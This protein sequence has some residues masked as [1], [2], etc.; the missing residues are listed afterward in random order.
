MQSRKPPVG[1]RKDVF[2]RH[3]KINDRLIC[4]TVSNYF[5]GKRM[6]RTAARIAILVLAGVLTLSGSTLAQ[7]RRQALAP[8]SKA[9]QTP[10]P[11]AFDLAK[12]DGEALVWLEGLI[13]IN[14][15]NPP[16]NEIVA[17]K[18]VADILKQEGINSEIIETTPGRGFLVARLSATAVPDPSRALLLMGHLDVV[19]VDKTKWTV[20]P[21]GAVVK[22]GYLYGRGAIDDKAMAVANLAVF[23]ALKRSSAHLNR[24]VIYLAEGDE[25]AGGTNGMKVAVEKY[26]DK[27]AAGFAINEGGYNV[28]K[29]GKVLYM[30]VQASEKVSVSVD[31][32]ATGVSG[33]GSLPRKDN[34]VVHLAAAIA[35]IGAYETPVQL[36]SVTRGYFEGL[37]AVEDDETAKWM[38]SLETSDRG[39][40]AARYL[41]NTNLLWNSMMRDTISPT[42][43]QAGIRANVI[44]SEARGV[45]NIRLLPGDMITVL[46]SKLTQLVND[47]QIR[48]EIQPGGGEA[49]PSSSL[50]TE[51]YNIITAASKQQFPGAAVIPFMSPGATDSYPLRMRSVE[52]YGLMPFPLQENDFLRMHADDER[53]PVDSFRKGVDFLYAI[54]NNFAVAH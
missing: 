51:L 28:Q 18:Y 12:L 2:W 46:L 31:V 49:A 34:P 10:T 3:A 19:G 4:S 35:K 53:I 36:N 26:W 37:A 30:A 32:I 29:D 38:R 24:D 41:S 16:G 20:D 7:A 1:A 52:A 8:Q 45:I 23:I 5:G 48:F 6:A 39:E 27:I 50:T 21:F 11:P 17:A 14:T 13:R 22:D 25:E 43:L 54:V 47:P 9:P 15:T 44:P 40:H 33:H 42:M